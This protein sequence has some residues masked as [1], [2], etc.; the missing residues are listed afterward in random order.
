MQS[1]KS[2]IQL[3]LH[4]RLQM[5]QETVQG[6]SWQSLIQ[7]KYYECYIANGLILCTELS[8]LLEETLH[9]ERDYK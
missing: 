9:C 5:K 2:C 4:H 6:D 8:F 7:D 1:S 3:Q